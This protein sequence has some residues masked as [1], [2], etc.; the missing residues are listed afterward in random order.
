MII[1][2]TA[3]KKREAE[4]RPI[5]VGIIGAGYM[6]RGMALTIEKAIPGMRVAAIY[7]RSPEKA[8]LALEQCGIDEFSEAK[9]A[10]DIEAAIENNRYVYCSD[11][12][13]LCEAGNIDAI[14]EA[15]GEVEFGAQV[16]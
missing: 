4:G 13:L 12:M 8:K 6:G 7:N 3:L 11:P 10:A 1:V 14:V 16:W 9:T 15:T 2:D 5:Q